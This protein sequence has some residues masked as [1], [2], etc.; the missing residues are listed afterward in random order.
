MSPKALCPASQPRYPGII[1]FSAVPQ[2]PWILIPSISLSFT[3]NISTVDVPI[4]F[5]SVFSP[6]PTP[7][8]PACASSDPVA[9]IAFSFRPNKFA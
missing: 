1:E 8:A 5:T 2:Q 7:T 9:T 6:I 3:I 4:T